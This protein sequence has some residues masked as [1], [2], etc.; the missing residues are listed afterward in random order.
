LVDFHVYQP[1]DELKCSHERFLHQSRICNKF[2]AESLSFQEKLIGRT[3]SLSNR[4]V[5]KDT[6]FTLDDGTGLGQETYFPKGIL[7]IPPQTTLEMAREEARYGLVSP[8][9]F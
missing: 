4:R 7:A 2:D 5:S 6:S 9:V 3:G 8:I 1:P